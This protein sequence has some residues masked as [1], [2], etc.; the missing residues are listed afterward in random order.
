MHEIV[1]KWC[2]KASRALLWSGMQIQVGLIVGFQPSLYGLVQVGPLRYG[3]RR[4]IN[5]AVR[6]E[7]PIDSKECGVTLA[8]GEDVESRVGEAD[9]ADDIRGLQ[10]VREASGDEILTQV[11]QEVLHCLASGCFVRRVQS[12]PRNLQNTYTLSSKKDCSH[13]ERG[14]SAM[15]LD[16]R[17][18]VSL[19]MPV[20]DEV[21]STF[22][23]S[24]GPTLIAFEIYIKKK[25]C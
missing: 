18:I 17:K 2:L 1:V 24:N 16:L 10:D 9:I 22:I 12:D 25:K 19:E 6:G 21:L 11:L 14:R 15:L 8:A 3:W 23:I 5:V 20:T 7:L 4:T 13:S